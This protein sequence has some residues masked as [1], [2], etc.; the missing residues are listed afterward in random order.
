MKLLSCTRCQRPVSFTPTRQEELRRCR[1]FLV[2]AAVLAVIAGGLYLAEVPLWPW[3][4]GG[5]ALYVLSQALLKWHASRWTF[6]EPCQNGRH[7]YFPRFQESPEGQ[8]SQKNRR[9]REQPRDGPQP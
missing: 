4:V 7:V 3:W 1:R 6:C 9:D 8:Q 2:F 5:T